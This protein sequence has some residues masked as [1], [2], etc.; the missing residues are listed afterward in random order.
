MARMWVYGAL[1]AFL[2]TFVAAGS[3]QAAVVVCQKGKKVTLRV[4]QC[5]PKESTVSL[6]PAALPPA[7][8]L[9]G[10]LEGADGTGSGLDADTLDGKDSSAFLGVNGKAADADKLDGKD[11][12]EFGPV[13]YAHVAADG[14]IDAA[15]SKNVIATS[16]YGV[17]GNYYCIDVAVPFKNVTVTP[18]SIA[19]II[20]V[21]QIGDPFTSC[22][23]FSVGQ[24]TGDATVQTFDH[25]GGG[26]T[27]KFWIV[28][29]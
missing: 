24:A 19:A 18:D 7:S 15:N 27:S 6:G 13:A 29:N 23:P 25:A 9:L 8:D 1:L 22:A 12:S 16:L 5:K 14:T 26:T 28:F 21:A 2:G 17:L 11:S 4:D 10:S 3:T 20:A